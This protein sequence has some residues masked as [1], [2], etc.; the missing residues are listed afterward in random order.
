MLHLFMNSG[1]VVIMRCS[2]CSFM[3]HKNKTVVLKTQKICVFLPERSGGIVLPIHGSAG[4]R[5]ESRARKKQAVK[6]GEKVRVGV[7][8]RD[9]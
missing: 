8:G 7:W 6:R 5:L 4:L 2:E 1:L 9:S 3:R